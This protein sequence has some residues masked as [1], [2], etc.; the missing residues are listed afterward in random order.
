MLVDGGGRGRLHELPHK[1]APHDDGRQPQRPHGAS[2]GHL[3]DRSD[4]GR[5]SSGSV[6]VSTGEPASSNVGCPRVLI[7][8]NG[9]VVG[10]RGTGS[11]WPAEAQNF[12]VSGLWGKGARRLMSSDKQASERDGAT[13]DARWPVHL[14]LACI[15]RYTVRSYKPPAS[16]R[17]RLV[18][19]RFGVLAVQFHLNFSK[20]TATSPM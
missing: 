9:G 10:S 14:V 7:E 18:E 8:G 4:R 5:R 11:R 17:R 3:G 13:Q 6:A 20:T 19:S 1:E 16:L 15:S 2:D 12:R